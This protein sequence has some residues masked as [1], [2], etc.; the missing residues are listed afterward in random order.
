MIGLC[1]YCG[2][3]VKIP[4]DHNGREGIKCEFCKKKIAALLKAKGGNRKA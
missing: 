1:F 3:P 2:N 4:P